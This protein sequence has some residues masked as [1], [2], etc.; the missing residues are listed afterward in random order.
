MFIYCRFSETLYTP[1]HFRA[2]LFCVS[3]VAKLRELKTAQDLILMFVIRQTGGTG[4]GKAFRKSPHQAFIAVGS[5]P[6]PKALFGLMFLR[7]STQ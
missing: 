7:V 3:H 5:T 1:K 4:V 6:N 2:G